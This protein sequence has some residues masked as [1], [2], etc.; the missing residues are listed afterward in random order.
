[1]ADNLKA[2]AFA[3][4][5]SDAER[6]E[7]EALN[8]TLSIHRELSNLPEAIAAQSY[9]SK[10]PLQQEALKKAAG[11][12]A[13]PSRGWLGTTWHYTGNQILRGLNEVGDLT[14]RL[15]RT[16]LFAN[17]EIPVK[18]H[19]EVLSTTFLRTGQ[20]LQMLGIKQMTKAKRF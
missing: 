18:F 20:F 17:R 4:G 9:N 13:A 3:A 14:T 10:T 2:A 6:R 1:M 8:K 7:V 12:D 15:Y 11:Q 5:L 19:L 16:G